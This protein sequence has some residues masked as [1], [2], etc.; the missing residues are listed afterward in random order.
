MMPHKL[1]GRVFID[2]INH[3][4]CPGY[5]ET[6]THGLFNIEEILIMNRPASSI[7]ISSVRFKD[8]YRVDVQI[9][10][11]LHE[12][13]W[14]VVQGNGKLFWG[15][16]GKV[17]ELE[18]ETNFTFIVPTDDEI[19]IYPCLNIYR[20]PLKEHDW[21]DDLVVEVKF[22]LANTRIYS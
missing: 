19:D 16:S 22:S 13:E 5:I 4:W 18:Y 11:R 15:T 7:S 3:E 20:L 17:E 14:I 10:P 2:T 21:I 1:A 8:V 12:S 6:L 9:I